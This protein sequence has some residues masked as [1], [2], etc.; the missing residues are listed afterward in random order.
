VL[1]EDSGEEGGIKK[2]WTGRTNGSERIQYALCRRK[3]GWRNCGTCWDGDNEKE[4]ESGV[5]SP[6]SEVHAFVMLLW[7]YAAMLWPS[8]DRVL[9]SL[10]CFSFAVNSAFL[11]FFLH[12][13]IFVGLDGCWL[14][15]FS[16]N[17]C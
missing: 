17:I 14:H 1:R 2:D 5:Q 12:V 13:S 11:F 4:G 15:C 7:F 3:M 16:V 9:F 6:K 10:Q 8:C